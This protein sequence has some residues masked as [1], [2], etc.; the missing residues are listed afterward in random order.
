ME[1][2]QVTD[3]DFDQIENNLSKIVCELDYLCETMCKEDSHVLISSKHNEDTVASKKGIVKE[4]WSAENINTDTIERV[5]MCEHP[6]ACDLQE[7]SVTYAKIDHRTC[8]NVDANQLYNQ[9]PVIDNDGVNY[10]FEPFNSGHLRFDNHESTIHVN[11][12]TNS[13][14]IHQNSNLSHL[15]KY[16]EMSLRSSR[17]NSQVGRHDDYDEIEDG[18]VL[19]ALPIVDRQ[20]VSVE[21]GRV[22]AAPHPYTFMPRGPTKGGDRNKNTT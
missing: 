11:E 2:D 5:S 17:S 10:L 4:D 1:T 13:H 15:N 7:G 14:I 20:L 8:I 19:H 16:S 9:N 6:S 22:Q 3:F 12:Q 21:A 18:V